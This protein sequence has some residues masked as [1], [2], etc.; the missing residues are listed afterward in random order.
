MSE[1]VN[2][3]DHYGGES[4]KYETIKVAEAWGMDKDAYLFN[5]LKYISRAGNKP[6][7]D[8]VEDLEKAVWYLERRIK[9][10]LRYD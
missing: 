4:N 10:L 9:L 7:S 1:S 8:E 3:P 2:H 6:G 5:A